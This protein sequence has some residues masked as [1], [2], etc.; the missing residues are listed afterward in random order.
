MRIYNLKLDSGETIAVKP[1][2]LR[3]YNNLLSAAN[4]GEAI[5]AIAEIIGRDTDYVCDNFTTDDAKRFIAGF[6]LWVENVKQ[7]D[8]N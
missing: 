2:K 3:H 5:T 7:S 6:P 1:P 4:D 8:P